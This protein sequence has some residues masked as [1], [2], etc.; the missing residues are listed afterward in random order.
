MSYDKINPDHYSG[1]I[2]CIEAIEASMTKEAFIG[3]LKG[4]VMKYIWRAGNT[5]SADEKEDLMKARWYLD[6]MIGL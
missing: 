6:K 2:E 5:P 4:N 3:F 1:S